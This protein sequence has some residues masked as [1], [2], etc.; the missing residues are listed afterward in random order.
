M[1][2]PYLHSLHPSHGERLREAGQGAK[3][4][5][6][7]LSLHLCLKLR[8]LETVYLVPGSICTFS[9]CR[10]R[11]IFGH[12]VHFS[13]V[14]AS[15]CKPIARQNYSSTCFS[16]KPVLAACLVPFYMGP[17]PPPLP[18]SVFVFFFGRDPFL[19]DQK[20]KEPDNGYRLG[21]PSGSRD[22]C[23]TGVSS[24]GGGGTLPLQGGTGKIGC[25]QRCG[26]IARP[27]EGG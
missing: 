7:P 3:L 20:K 11:V 5:I 1:G 6:A 12:H 2:S 4:L 13:L 18:P 9:P 24:V 15:V 14:L 23:L 10:H 8:Y 16:C 25:D 19:D 27:N 26:H 22:S 17:P 21:E